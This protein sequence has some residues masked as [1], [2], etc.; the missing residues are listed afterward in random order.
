MGSNSNDAAARRAARASWPITRH[1]LNSDPAD[2]LSAVTTPA[3]RIA[4]M[5]E[6]AETAWRLAGRPL[7]AYARHEIP[8]RL[9]EKG[10]ARPDNDDP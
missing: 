4:M 5:K 9:F 8:G 10:E 1:D 6:L 3:E 7:P 2:D